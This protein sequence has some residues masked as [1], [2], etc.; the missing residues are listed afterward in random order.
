[1]QERDET[2][3]EEKVT[4]SSPIID[5][6]YSVRYIEREAFLMLHFLGGKSRKNAPRTMRK[7]SAMDKRIIESWS[8][9]A[10][11]H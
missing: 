1:M 4:K 5:D 10:S 2:G 7:L 9:D 11:G 8:S 3:K 6:K